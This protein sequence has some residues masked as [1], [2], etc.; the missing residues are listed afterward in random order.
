MSNAMTTPH[1]GKS[2]RTFSAARTSETILEHNFVLIFFALI[3]IASLLSPNFLTVQNVANLF[4]QATIV[5]ITAVGMTFVILTANID[6]SVGSM[7][8]FGGVL[9]AVIMR[10]TRWG[11]WDLFCRDATPGL[12]QHLQPAWPWFFLPNDGYRCDHRPGHTTQPV[13]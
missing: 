13:D 10:R 11:Y 5:G 8:A 1:P 3:V 9:V 4:Q 7:V 6:L 2:K 12:T